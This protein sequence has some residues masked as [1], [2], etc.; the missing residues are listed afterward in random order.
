MMRVLFIFL[1]AS[2]VIHSIDADLVYARQAND[3]TRFYELRVY[4]SHPG[5]QDALLERFR[6][7]TVR[8]FARLDIHTVGH[9]VPTENPNLLYYIVS[10]ESREQREAAWQ[11]FLNDPE[12]KRVYEASR[13][14]GPLVANI[15]STYLSIADYSVPVLP[16][17]SSSP[18]FFELRIYTAN[19]NKLDDLHARFRDHTV[20]IFSSHGM[21]HVGYWRLT[22]ADQGAADKLLYILAYEDEAARQ[23]AWADFRSNPRWVEAKEASERNGALVSSVES[24]FMTPT[25]YSP[26]N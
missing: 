1:L 3:D 25:D 22:D 21:E 16:L 2:F 19:E 24:I 17:S 6:R 18:R 14:N 26:I 10:Y 23:Q 9:W 11:A 8:I 15:E 20:D 13:E 12:W 5:K 4:E 7:H